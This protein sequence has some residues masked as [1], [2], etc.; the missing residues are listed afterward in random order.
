M[1]RSRF[2][3]AEL[4]TALESLHELNVIYRDVKPEIS[5]WIIKVILPYVILDC[6][7]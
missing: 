4:L 7:N 2:Y 6:V 3:I 1:D 5:Y